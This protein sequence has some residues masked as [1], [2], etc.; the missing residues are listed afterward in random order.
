MRPV[1]RRQSCGFTLLELLVV[2]VLI[3]I[4]VSFAVLSIGDGGRQE[5]LK[6]EAQRIHALFALASEEAVLRS[7]ELGVI[8]QRQAYHF[9]VYDGEVWQPLGGDDMFRDR[10]LP[11][12][13]NI[14]LFMDGLPSE[15]EAGP[16]KGTA[17]TA[18]QLLFFSSGERTPFELVLEYRDAPPLAYRLQAPPLGAMLLERLEAAF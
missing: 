11:E 18:P 3:G 15:L 14:S 1:C 8:V 4:I 16:T 17:D 2:L 13:V 6:Q 9:V 5:R 10:S 7:L 12:T